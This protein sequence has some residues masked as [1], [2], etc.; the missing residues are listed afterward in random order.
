MATQMAVDGNSL[1]EILDF[2]EWR[3]RAVLSYVNETQVDSIQLDETLTLS[4][5][6]GDD[7]DDDEEEQLET[8][9]KRGR[10]V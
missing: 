3:S 2:G 5:Q 9:A 8:P 10:A 4:E 7:D 1:R 6:E